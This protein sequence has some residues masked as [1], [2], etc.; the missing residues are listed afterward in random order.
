VSRVPAAPELTDGA[1]PGGGARVEL[2]LPPDVRPRC[3]GQAAVELTAVDVRG[4]LAA[5]V[6]T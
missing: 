3:G 2:A 4:L 6:T 5:L 1:A